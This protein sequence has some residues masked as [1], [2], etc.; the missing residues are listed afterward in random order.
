ECGWLS[1]KSIILFAS[2]RSLKPPLIDGNQLTS[3][4]TS[5]RRARCD[6]SARQLAPVLS[7]RFYALGPAP[8]SS[9]PGIAGRQPF[10]ARSHEAVEKCG[11]EE[12]ESS[13]SGEDNDSENDDALF[14]RYISWLS[15]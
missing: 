2:L 6:L 13:E 14:G 5:E 15:R 12:D 1:R 11:H 10:D 4:G 9:R 8:P 3:A 7:M